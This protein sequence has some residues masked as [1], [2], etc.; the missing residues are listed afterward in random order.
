[1]DAVSPKVKDKKSPAGGMEMKT[2]GDSANAEVCD[3]VLLFPL[4]STATDTKKSIYT[5]EFYVKKFLGLREVKSGDKAGEEFQDKSS[6]IYRTERC[7]LGLDGKLKITDA[8]R[9]SY[10]QD[11]PESRARSQTMNQAHEKEQLKEKK[12]FLEEEYQELLDGI[13]QDQN[14]ATPADQHATQREFSLLVAK[15][16]AKRIQLGCGLST[17]MSFSYDQDEIMCTVTADLNDLMV[18][19]DRTDF[20]VQYENNPFRTDNTP[21]GIFVQEFLTEFAKKPVTEGDSSDDKGLSG[22]DAIDQAKD[23]LR[24]VTDADPTEIRDEEL[25]IDPGMWG[26]AA[27]RNQPQLHKQFTMRGHNEDSHPDDGNIY[28]A[29]YT[30]FK[31]SWQHQPL[32]RHYS[33]AAEK[34]EPG[35]SVFRKIDRIK[36]VKSIMQRHLNLPQLE[37]LK[38]LTDQYAL[39]EPEKLDALK[40]EW[41]LCLTVPNY[42]PAWAGGVAQPLGRI[43]DYFGAKIA[44]YFAWL[45]FYTYALIPIAI[46]G[47]PAFL[48]KN[49]EVPGDMKGITLVIFGGIVSVWSTTFTEFW[50]RRNAFLNVW[51]GTVGYKKLEQPRAGFYGSTRSSPIDDSMESFHTNVNV[52]IRKVIIGLC[53]VGFMI[54][55]VIAAVVGILFLK[56]VLTVQYL[57]TDKDEWTINPN[58][59]ALGAPICGGLNA[60]QIMILN[61]VYRGVADFLNDWEN[62]RTDSEY[63]NNLITKVFLFQFVNSYASFFIIA[64]IKKSFMTDGFAAPV[65]TTIDN[66]TGLPV[67]WGADNDGGDP[68]LKSVKV[69]SP[70]TGFTVGPVPDSGCLPFADSNGTMQPDCMK[71]LQTQLATIFLINLFVGN[72]NEI[73]I[74]YL[75]YKFKVFMEQRGN[76]SGEDIKYDEAEEQS[77]LNKYEDKESFN[78]YSEMVIQYGFVTLFVVGFPLTPLLAFVNNVAEVHVDS[79]KLTIGHRR[80]NPRG[81]ENIGT[82]NDFL[83]VMSTISVMTNVGLVFFTANYVN[84]VSCDITDVAD[85]L[86]TCADYEGVCDASTNLCKEATIMP[87]TLAQRWLAFLICEHILLLIKSVVGELVPDMPSDC[88]TFASRF[89]HMSKRTFDNLAED[90]DSGL[91]EKAEDNIDLSIGNSSAGV[92]G[93][94]DNPIVTRNTGAEQI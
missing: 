30:A 25:A 12:R 56:K 24:T 21:R 23:I 11:A 84:Q 41:A 35:S 52:F 5:K 91:E 13:R 94:V 8:A 85:S 9:M 45:Q 37:F 19:A 83:A 82:W 81:V 92:S 14:S 29:G 32:Y 1:M 70:P 46:L 87:Q 44:L 36:L 71:E 65:I 62:H 76:T 77:K 90:D 43:R 55:I 33:I 75:G 10:H 64:F 34:K 88:E 42:L 2:M 28:L 27:Q 79:I 48:I 63:E 86:V 78:D 47:V 61:I 80:P 51:W 59:S 26:T 67:P 3:L 7:Y 18:E 16:I 20:L 93:S 54:C 49:A 15:A 73:M 39:H 22:A 72:M 6:C 66:S 58:F 53:V 74:P 38:L 17:S 4:C 40:N 50:K 68:A 60:V 57:S 69:S 89:D 31:Y